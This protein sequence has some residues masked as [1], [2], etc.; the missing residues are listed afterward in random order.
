MKRLIHAVFFV[1]M[2]VFIGAN[3]LRAER[4]EAGSQ[5]ALIGTAYQTKTSF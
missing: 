4:R 1:K 5:D 2:L 3:G